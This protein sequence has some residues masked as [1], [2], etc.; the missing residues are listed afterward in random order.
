MREAGI[1]FKVSQHRYPLGKTSSDDYFKIGVPPEFVEEA[2]KLIAAGNLDFDDSKEDQKIMEV[3]AEGGPETG[4]D[5]GEEDDYSSKKGRDG[6]KVEIWSGD[7]GDVEMIEMCLKENGIR[8]FVEAGEKGKKR[9]SVA[10]EHE[11][12][13]RQIVKELDEGKPE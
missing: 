1:P 7:A 9:L 10:F 11:K 8:A 12:K 2:K 6:A 4:I 3:P 5:A 13:A